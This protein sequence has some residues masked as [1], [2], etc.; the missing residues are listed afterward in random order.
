MSLVTL[1]AASILQKMTFTFGSRYLS[2]RQTLSVALSAF[3]CKKSA[4]L[5]ILKQTQTSI[6]GGVTSS[7]LIL[8][9]LIVLDTTSSN[10]DLRWKINH[11]LSLFIL[12]LHWVGSEG[13][14]HVI[15]M[16][17][18]ISRTW[19]LLIFLW[20]ESPVFDLLMCWQFKVDLRDL[21]L[22]LKVR[23][24]YFHSAN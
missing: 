9:Y 1:N 7:F 10:S 11:I 22:L 8:F 21:F 4:S 15:H 16:N 20:S 5:S 17:R 19:N 6:S 24:V 2:L 18:N 14:I 13:K 23:L 3:L 12:N